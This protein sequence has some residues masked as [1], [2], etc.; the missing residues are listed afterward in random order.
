M[1]TSAP[2]PG[3]YHSRSRVTRTRLL[4]A[5]A[6]LA[7]LLLGYLIG[8]L[9][10]GSDTPAAAAV[11]APPP[12]P[13]ASTEAPPPS[14]SPSPSTS[15]PP[16]GLDPYNG[17]QAEAAS[18]QQGT[19][20]QDTEDEGGGQNVGWINNGDWLRYDNVDF[21]DNP[22][23]HFAARVASD[24]DDEARGRIEIRLDSPA[25]E[26]IGTMDVQDTDGWQDWETQATDVKPVT[27]RHTLFITFASARGTEF[28]NINYLGFTH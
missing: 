28:M 14:P 20:F 17:L 4:L 22:A 6:G 26:P 21:G 5:G 18:A 1:T 2:P 15:P 16:P 27:G 3:V 25:N 9:Q 7:L 13:A 10:G 12:P 23:A 8:R 24:V 11:V 19:E